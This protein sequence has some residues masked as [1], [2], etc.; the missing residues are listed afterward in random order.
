VISLGRGG[1]GRHF[2]KLKIYVNKNTRLHIVLRACVQQL[3][4]FKRANQEEKT[5]NNLSKI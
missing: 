2:N 5:K 3:L 1:G 4:F